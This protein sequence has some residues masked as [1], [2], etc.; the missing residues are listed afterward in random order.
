VP[1]K[2]LDL[3]QLASRY[4]TEPSTGT[5][6]IVRRQF[7]HADALGRICRLG[8]KQRSYSFPARFLVEANPISSGRVVEFLRCNESK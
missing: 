2:E 4:M 6:Q 3:L 8:Q 7:R 1:Q 5:S